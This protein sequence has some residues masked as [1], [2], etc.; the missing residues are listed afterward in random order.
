MLNITMTTKLS[1]LL[2]AALM[3]IA[4]AGS[5]AKPAA[6]TTDEQ[7]TVPQVLGVPASPS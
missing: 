2:I 4:A 7:P 1:F 3:M 6:V 5:T